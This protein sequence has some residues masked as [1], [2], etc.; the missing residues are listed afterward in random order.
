MGITSSTKKFL[1]Y[2][3]KRYNQLVTKGHFEP[4]ELGI[5]TT[6]R[7]IDSSFI[8]EINRDRTNPI[9]PIS[10]ERILRDLKKRG[11]LEPIPDNPLLFVPTD[12]AFK[13]VGIE[14]IMPM[15]SKI[16]N[17]EIS[18]L[19]RN[20]IHRNIECRVCLIVDGYL[21][22]EK[23]CRHCGAPLLELDKL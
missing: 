15:G 22:E 3:C 17:K 5:G 1:E 12:E 8:E 9:K 7:R 13:E 10:I 2:I 23:K 18:D 20:R 6:I 14:K 4:E 16:F 11:F 19:P 21:P